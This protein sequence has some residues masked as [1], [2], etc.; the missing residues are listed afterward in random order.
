MKK[1]RVYASS[2][3]ALE[4]VVTLV[5]MVLGPRVVVMHFGASGAA[6]SWGGRF[7]LL[8]E[9]AALLVIAFV[10]DRIV[11]RERRREDLVDFP[12]LLPSE[13]R[14][15]A[16]MVAFVVAF[17]LLQLYQIGWLH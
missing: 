2:L 11:L 5:L 13:W 14:Y 7:G 8:L 3:V 4:F 6:D 1:Y 16:L 9:P 10:C 12:E 15:V 17:A